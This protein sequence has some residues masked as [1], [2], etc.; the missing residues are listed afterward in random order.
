MDE[1]MAQKPGFPES[2]GVRSRFGGLLN[3]RALPKVG[4]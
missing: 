2:R 1:Q 3:R 4:Q